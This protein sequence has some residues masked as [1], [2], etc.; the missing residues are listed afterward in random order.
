MEDIIAKAEHYRVRAHRKA[1]GHFLAES[2][3]Q[4]LNNL[5]GVPVVITTTIVGT[6]IFATLDSTPDF[7]VKISTGLLSIAAAVL[8]A[9]HTFFRY[10]EQAERH[11]T[12]AGN[13]YVAYRALDLFKLRQ[14]ETGNQD[15]SRAIDELET[16]LLQLNQFDKESPEF[17]D[18]FYDQA[19][20][21]E[22]IDND[23][24]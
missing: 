7:R 24:V 3:A 20:R 5:L 23:S 10:S 13:Y 16:I 12:A 15:R 17:P 14:S 8:A 9:L 21:E 6:T 22:K 4:R 2:R 18:R 19:V 1:R 11:R